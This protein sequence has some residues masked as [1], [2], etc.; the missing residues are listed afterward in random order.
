[1]VVHVTIDRWGDVLFFSDPGFN[2]V[3]DLLPFCGWIP[4]LHPEF[5]M[6]KPA[7]PYRGGFAPFGECIAMLRLGTPGERPIQVIHVDPLQHLS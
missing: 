4:M 6:N 1:M 7:R 3:S 5:P 2:S